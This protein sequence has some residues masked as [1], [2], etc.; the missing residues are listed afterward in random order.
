M[1]LKKGNLYTDTNRKYYDYIGFT[2]NSCLNAKKELVMGAGNAKICKEMYP[3]APAIFGGKIANLSEFNIKTSIHLGVFAL[4]T[5][6]DW[7]KKS[8]VNL[9]K[10]SIGRLKD[11]GIAYPDLK[12]A[13]PFPGISH[14]GLRREEILP[15]LLELPDNIH[16][17]EM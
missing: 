16:I 3:S 2:A 14:G 4:Q 5:K 1:I 13:C 11:F 17:W 6:T 8:D 15:M 9:V 7:R 10:R 12:L